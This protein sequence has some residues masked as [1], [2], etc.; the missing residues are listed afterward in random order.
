MRM[1]QALPKQ[2]SC[3]DPSNTEPFIYVDLLIDHLRDKYHFHIIHMSLEERNAVA[4]DILEYA[5]TQV[6][7]TVKE[8]HLIKS[9][10][11]SIMS[12]I[13]H[14]IKLLYTV[15]DLTAD[16]VE[17]D[18]RLFG[19]KP[20][21]N[22]GELLV[23]NMILQFIVRYVCCQLL[24][25][26]IPETITISR[27]CIIDPVYR[28]H[29]LYYQN[30][31]SLKNLIVSHLHLLE[32]VH[33]DMKLRPTKLICFTTTNSFLHKL[34]DKFPTEQAYG[35]NMNKTVINDIRLCI[36]ERA[37]RVC[38][39]S[40]RYFSTREHF[41]RELKNFLES[42]KLTVMVLIINVQL[43]STRKI[44]LVRHMIEQEERLV[45][46]CRKLF[47]LILHYS[48]DIFHSQQ[49]FNSSNCDEKQNTSRYPSHFVLGWDHYYI[50]SIC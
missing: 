7:N 36:F 11:I 25:L 17:S 16:F 23:C 13:P 37:E 41:L 2:G 21:I 24:K 38:L 27:N 26:T 48:P 14:T 29:Y 18:Q 22:H 4:M 31:F 50:D 34:P 30:H 42:D 8:Y 28:K 33:W 6:P 32:E 10:P 45:L 47:A 40:L 15:D 19:L 44:N 1:H 35:V 49:G 20:I 43:V 46:K 39:F 3:M 5:L 12:W 9:D